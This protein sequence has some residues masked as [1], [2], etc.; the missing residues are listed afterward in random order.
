MIIKDAITAVTGGGHGLGKA[1]CRRFASGGA[2]AV[3]VIDRDGEAAGAVAD[4]IGGRAYAVDVSDEAALA[5]A[6]GDIESRHGRIDLFCSNAGVGFDDGEASNATGM[7]ND[8][9]Q[10]CWEVNVM[11]QV[12]AARALLPGMI[13]RGQGHLVNVA[14]AAGLLSQ[15]GGT[16]YSATKHASVGFTESLAITHGDQGLRVS[17]VCPQAIATAMIGMPDEPEDGIEL[18]GIAGNDVDGVLWPDQAADLIAEGIEADRFLILTHDSV[19]DYF[20]RKAAD[21]DR[22]IGGMRKL[23]RQVLEPTA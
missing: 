11:A 22:W 7:G 3:A 10:Q 17:L 14:S 16:A 9:W 1:L 5:A 4:E 15:I 18:K 6:I 21:Y 19:D 2:K 13:E 23:R 20:R 8:L 12:Y